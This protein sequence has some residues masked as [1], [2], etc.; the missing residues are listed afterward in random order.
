[1]ITAQISAGISPRQ[2]LEAARQQNNSNNII[3]RDIYN[4]QQKIYLEL[5]DG[6]P[7]IQAL[8]SVLLK[9]H[10]WL[11][12]YMTNHENQLIRLFCTQYSCLE[13]LQQNPYV[14]IMDCTYKTNKYKM[15]LLN[16]NGVTATSNS[17]YRGFVF[18]YNK[19]QDSYN[20]ALQN[21][22]KVYQQ[23][24]LLSPITILTNKEA[25]LI[26]ACEETFPTANVI[27]CLWHVNMNI[28]LKARPC[29]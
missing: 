28:L 29:L 4:I 16:I 25:A 20:F 19:K 12:N 8:L 15:P 13:L 27:I 10:Q 22:S 24:G 6:R 5:L 23:L 2:I 26:N 21:L 9:K 11:F 1:M 18:L 17:F 7:P 14:L 3:P